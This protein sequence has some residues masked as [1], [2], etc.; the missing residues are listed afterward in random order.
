MRIAARGVGSLGR[1]FGAVVPDLWRVAR[2]LLQAVRRR[3]DEMQGVITHVP[4]RFGGAGADD[5]G[6]RAV[7]VSAVSLAPNGFV[8][9]MDDER[10]ELIVHQ[11]VP[12]AIRD[13][14]EWPL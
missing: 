3:P 1:A 4:F 14:R 13:D 12:G 11:L 2:G 10:N 9:G 5:A 7:V 6:R 8:V